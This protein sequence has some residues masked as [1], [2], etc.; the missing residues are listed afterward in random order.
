MART[1]NQVSVWGHRSKFIYRSPPPG[2]PEIYYTSRP[3]ALVARNPLQGYYQVR[4]PS[5]EGY[6]AA[7]SLEGPG[8]DGD[9][10]MQLVTSL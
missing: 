7:P 6:L 3:P 2:P 8:P 1:P 10:Q 4:R 5:H 9:G